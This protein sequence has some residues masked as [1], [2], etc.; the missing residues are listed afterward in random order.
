[1]LFKILLNSVLL[2]TSIDQAQYSS[3]RKL[4]LVTDNI[5]NAQFLEQE[6]ILNTDSAGIEERDLTIAI[7]TS[8]NNKALYSKWMN[9][10][11]GFRLIL[12]GKDGG[13]K[14]TSDIPISFQQLFAIVDAM[15][16]RQQEIRSAKRN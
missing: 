1:M 16:M 5:R 15:P 10:R 4:L 2:F 13:E 3:K 11:K 9:N 12:I 6:K 7:V 8:S 14:F